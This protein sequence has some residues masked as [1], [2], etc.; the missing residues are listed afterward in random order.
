MMPLYE[1]NCNACGILFE[2]RHGYKQEGITCSSCGSPSIAKNLSSVLHASKKSPS[3]KDTRKGS[4]VI[5][6]IEEG[7]R[8]LVDFKKM[9]INRT[10]NK[11]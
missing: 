4:E 3:Q 11:K 1:Y 9:K 5:K 6:A 8:E 7:K 10:Y 2:I